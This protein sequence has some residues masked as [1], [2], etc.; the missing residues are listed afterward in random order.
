[1]KQVIIFHGTW[2]H[3]EQFWFPYIQKNLSSDDYEVFVPQLPNPD[4]PILSDWLDFVFREY[5]FNRDTILVWHSAGC[6]LILSILERISA[7]IDRVILVSGFCEDLTPWEG[8][9]ILQE[10]YNWKKIR[11][12][13][14]HFITINSKNDPW[15]CDDTQGQKIFDNVWWDLIIR[16]GEWHMGSIKF[17][18]P[19]R[20]FPLLLSL[21]QL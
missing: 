9:P 12:N 20:E 3:P 6:P 19:Y 16:E 13:A 8:N 10:E 14:R 21:I 18:Q 2:G 17:N 15:W 4:T 7:P 5:E 11:N 1:M